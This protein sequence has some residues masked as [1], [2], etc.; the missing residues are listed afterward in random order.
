MEFVR[1]HELWSEAA[2]QAAQRIR[3]RLGAGELSRLRFGWA[4]QHGLVRGKT[5]HGQR[6]ID[7]LGQGIGFVG[8][9]LLK[10]T[11][12]R[13]TRPV[14]THGAGFDSA[15]FEGAGDVLLVPDPLTF[16]ELPWSAGSGWVQCQAMF[17]DGR[18]VPYDTR[19]ILQKSIAEAADQ[20][21][22]LIVGLEVECHIFK[23]DDPSLH[24]ND[25]GWPGQPPRVS[26]VSQGY[27]LLS[28][29]R[30]DRLEPILD[31]LTEP[32]LAMGLPIESVEIELGPS[33]VEFVFAPQDALASADTMLLFRHAAKQIMQRH[34]YHISF[35]CRPRLPQAMSSGWH[36][37]QS[38]VDTRTGANLFG[39][40]TDSEPTEAPLSATG[41]AYLAGLLANAPAAAAFTTPTI[42]GYR[43]YR[44]N[45]LAPERINWGQDNRGAMIRLIGGGKNP[46]TRLENRVGEPA[47]NPYL[48]IAAQLVA[49]LDGI[50]RQSSPPAAAVE[51]YSDQYELLPRSLDEAVAALAANTMYAESFG[52]AFIDYYLQLKQFELARFHLE[53][54]DWEQAEYFDLF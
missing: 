18:L 12:D 37:H 21:M 31:L 44:P 17:P 6:A 30:Y 15:E 43:R 38:L 34:G 11:S 26:A 23:L 3:N 40:I 33:Q 19:G 2:H 39:T 10:D 24:A 1:E 7:A 8:T 50:A 47:A 53:V 25:L 48:S 36:L 41:Q 22:K 29:Q 16:V 52:P 14:F 42:N 45:A 46:A 4:D 20:S 54:T 27:R 35:M 28:E 49:G 51:P 32:L 5:L 13:T 9:N